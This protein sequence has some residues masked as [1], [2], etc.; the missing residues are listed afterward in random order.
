MGCPD[1]RAA[2]VAAAAVLAATAGAGRAGE[3][4]AIVAEIEAG[5]PGVGELDLLER[6]RVLTLARGDR[7]VLGYLASCA[8]EVLEGPGRARVGERQ[9]ALDG[10][11]LRDRRTV[12]CQSAPVPG[13]GSGNGAATRLRSLSRPSAA[14]AASQQQL[15]QEPATLLPALRAMRQNGGTV[16]TARH[17]QP[18]LLLPDTAAVVTLEPLDRQ[19]KARRL[20]AAGG[21][22]VDTMGSTPPLEPGL[23][24]ARRGSLDVRFTVTADAGTGER[25][26]RD[27]LLAY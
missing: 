19:G 4:A 1:M 24:R 17:R 15:D 6:D 23:W 25:P 27:R 11:V 12:D 9:S 18:A 26:A 16:G 22:L 20:D 5:S 10:A 21:L 2:L 3:P 13:T 8:R 7:V 14:A